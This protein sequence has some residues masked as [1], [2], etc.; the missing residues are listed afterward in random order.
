MR[1]EKH[2]IATGPH[3]TRRQAVEAGSGLEPHSHDIRQRIVMMA[4]EQPVLSPG[5][6][7]F[8]A[9]ARAY[10]AVGSQVET[11][12]GLI[13]ALDAAFRTGGVH[14]S[15]APVDYSENITVLINELRSAAVDRR[16]IARLLANE[17]VQF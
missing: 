14:L 15:A 2:L 3:R 4:F 10:H 7:D 17:S 8:A 12:D 1:F 6:P 9:Y 5:N 11:A 13:P 16:K